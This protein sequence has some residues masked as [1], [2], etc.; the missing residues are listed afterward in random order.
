MSQR[1]CDC[2]PEVAQLEEEVA[3][4][5]ATFDRIGALAD[6]PAYRAHA[7]ALADE[8][9]VWESAQLAH[10]D[11]ERRAATGLDAALWLAV[12]EPRDETA[13][14]RARAFLAAPADCTFLVL[15]GPKG[16]GKTYALAWAVKRRGGRYEDAAALVSSSTF[17]ADRWRDLAAAPLLAL[18]ELGAEQTN[19]AFEANLYALLDRRYRAQRKTILATNLSAAAFRQRYCAAGLDRLIDRFNTAGAFVELAA[20]PSLRTHWSETG[21]A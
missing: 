3:R 10:R 12:D 13:L 6:D 16:R 2:G 21:G 20:G 14:V 7:E 11:E 4:L 17:D 19:S 15:A 8:W 9:R 18:D 1:E 5:R